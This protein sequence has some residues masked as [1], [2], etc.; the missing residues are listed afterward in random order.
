[1]VEYE[2]RFNDLSCFAP[3]LVDTEEKRC[4]HFLEGLRPSIRDLLEDLRLTDYVD[5]V[6]RAINKEMRLNES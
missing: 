4:R 5:L 1:M 2:D 3:T 6:D